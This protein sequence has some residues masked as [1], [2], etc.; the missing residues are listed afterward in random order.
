[1]GNQSLA[2]LLFGWFMLFICSLVAFVDQSLEESTYMYEACVSRYRRLVRKSCSLR[3]APQLTGK[4]CAKHSNTEVTASLTV[5]S[6]LARCTR[7]SV[8]YRDPSPVMFNADLQN[9]QWSS[10]V[11]TLTLP[12]PWM[13]VAPGS[14]SVSARRHPYCHGNKHRGPAIH[15]QTVLMV[16]R[17]TGGGSTH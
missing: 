2:R 4:L 17:P 9:D 13:S 5:D 3:V 1:M 8:S 11:L 12:G 6:F 10:A 14:A 7:P 16:S 15:V